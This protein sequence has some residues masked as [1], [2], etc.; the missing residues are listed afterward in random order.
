MS[1]S[2]AIGLRIPPEV[3]DK[4]REYGLEHYPSDKSKEKI[5]VTQT[6]TTLLK[7]ALGI[8]LDD[9]VI[10]SNITL[11]ER[12]TS[13]VKQLLDSES[14]NIKNSSKVALD[15]R[16]TVIVRRLL[17]DVT[18]PLRDE[19]SEVAELSRDLQREIAALSD[20]SVE[21]PASIANVQSIEL[22]SDEST[23]T[24]RKTWGEFFKMVGLVAMPSNAAQKE[25][26][27]QLRDKQA[28]DG[29]AKAKELGRGA[30]K[31]SRPGRDFVR[32]EDQV[33]PLPLFTIN[34]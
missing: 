28:S 19:I 7:Q 33:A 23:L 9:Y 25:E 17:D 11:D 24:N 2:K 27:I 10:R 5:D 32:V 26:N 31:V 14:D 30:W 34:E 22:P 20:R 8:S 3:W 1:E 15:E 21:I 6:I 4:L 12:I 13:I 16:I 29:I 18:K